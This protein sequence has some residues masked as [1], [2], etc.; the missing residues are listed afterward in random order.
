MYIHLLHFKARVCHCPLPMVI[1]I[2]AFFLIC[3]VGCEVYQVGY[4]T[5]QFTPAEHETSAHSAASLLD[6]TSPLIVLYDD[7]FRTW[8]GRLTNLTRELYT[9]KNETHTGSKSKPQF[10]ELHL[11]FR[12]CGNIFKCPLF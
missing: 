12:I 1:I 11:G 8:L 9:I 7:R 4:L 6:H 5:P 2:D 10:G 3:I